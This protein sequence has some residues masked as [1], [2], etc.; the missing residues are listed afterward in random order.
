VTEIHHALVLN[1]HQPPSNLDEL[2]ETDEW[3]VK[4]VLFA[5]DRM[6]RVLWTYEDLARVHL[7]M[8]GT[9]LETLSSPEFQRRVY[10][11][12]NYGSLLW[13]LQ[14]VRIRA[15]SYCPSAMLRVALSY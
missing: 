14:N 11:I 10:G 5:Y 6:P 4:E 7:S 15:R 8:S 1:P 9:L 13:W 3:E 2:L 12:V